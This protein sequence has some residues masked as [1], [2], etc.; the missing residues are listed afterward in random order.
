MIVSSV[1]F[2]FTRP[3]GSVGANLIEQKIGS[4]NSG[5]PIVHD[6]LDPSMQKYGLLGSWPMDG[7]TRKNNQRVLGT[8]TE[9]DYN[10]ES[11]FF[12]LFISIF[13]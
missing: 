4:K 8:K 7:F 6:F 3:G 5:N 12:W 13:D 1:L 11:G 2:P 9:I 10:L